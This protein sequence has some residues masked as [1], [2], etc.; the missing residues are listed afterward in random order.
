MSHPFAGLSPQ[1]KP[2]LGMPIG[3]PN[4]GLPARQ[5]PGNGIIPD[6]KSVS[7][8]FNRT[9]TQRYL[10]RVVTHENEEGPLL[11]ESVNS[12]QCP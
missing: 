10:S 11:A 3:F 5:S 6:S 9:E 1:N 8:R 4:A 7:P 2:P 12:R